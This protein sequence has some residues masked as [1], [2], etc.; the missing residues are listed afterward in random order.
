MT[1]KFLAAILIAVILWSAIYHWNA[2][3]LAA[4]LKMTTTP[5]SSEHPSNFIIIK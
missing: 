2:K 1:N 3:G 4:G 5:E